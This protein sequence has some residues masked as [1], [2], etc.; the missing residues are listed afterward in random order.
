[1]KNIF[2]RLGIIL[3]IVVSVSGSWLY[4][5][6]LWISHV[7]KNHFSYMIQ[8]TV[9]D[10][11]TILTAKENNKAIKT[12]VNK[13]SNKTRIKSIVVTNK[14]GTNLFDIRS[15]EKTDFILS[16]LYAKYPIYSENKT[17][18][19]IKINPSQEYLYR[20]LFS[21]YNPLILL[22]FLLTWSLS[23]SLVIYFY[24]HRL[25]VYQIREL[26]TRFAAAAY[27]NACRLP[28][29][30]ND[31]LPDLRVASS[32]NQDERPVD[33]HGQFTKINHAK[34]GLPE[35]SFCFESA[36]G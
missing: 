24:L 1:M 28:N 9:S 10:L 30:T 5:G 23:T 11:S 20:A 7:L 14:Q 34:A 36:F 4:F 18:G 33:L 25:K 19:W 22:F 27:K 8:T 12:V 35:K 29:V 13:F 32:K 16:T 21:G 3:L 6:N 31:I 15:K 2:Q 17:I 26:N